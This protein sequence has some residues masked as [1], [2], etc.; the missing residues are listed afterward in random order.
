MT[1]SLLKNQKQILRS[2]RLTVQE[3]M[4]NLLKL[5]IDGLDC[6]RYLPSARQP[7]NFSHLPHLRRSVV[8]LESSVTSHSSSTQYSDARNKF[9]RKASIARYWH[10]FQP[11]TEQPTVI[12]SR[13][14]QHNL[15]RNLKQDTTEASNEETAKLYFE[16]AIL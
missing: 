3:K 8:H 13:L 12:R 4:T 15:N 11:F 7:H 9:S 10:C 5:M 14:Y 6:N 2:A 16:G 1:K